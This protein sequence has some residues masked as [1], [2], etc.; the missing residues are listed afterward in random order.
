MIEAQVVLFAIQ[1]TLK[2]YAGAR[3]AYVDATLDREL[4]LPLPRA[5]DLSKNI[6]NI[7]Q[8]F[9]TG[10]GNEVRLENELLQTLLLDPT[11]NG[12]E[13]RT[14]YAYYFAEINDLD[15]DDMKGVEISAADL[16]HMLTIRQWG[17]N[18]DPGHPG[19]F[20]RMAGTIVE[21]A[22]DYFATMPG[23]V[24]E[25]RPE[26]RALLAFLK[27]MSDIE[28]ATENPR[29]LI[30]GVMI[31]V[32]DA[33]AATPALLVTGEKEQLLIVGMSTALAKA[34]DR[35]N[36]VNTEKKK[37]DAADWARVVAAAVARGAT[38]TVLAN[39]SLFLGKTDVGKFVL[40]DV[41]AQVADLAFGADK[42]ELQ[43]VLSTDGLTTIAQTA[44]GAISRN[45]EILGSDNTGLTKL[46]REVTGTLAASK[47]KAGRDLA[48]HVISLVLE[49]SAAN[50]DMLWEGDRNDPGRNLLVVAAKQT[51]TVL[52]GVVAGPATP[53]T[54]AQDQLVSIVDAVFAQV[55]ANPA[56]VVDQITGTHN[57]IVSAALT[58]ALA[59]MKGRKPSQFGAE[60][61]RDVL[62]A[63]I[64]AV[65]TRIEFLDHLPAGDAAAGK[66]FLT[67]VLDAILSAALEQPMPDSRRW[68][69]A[70][71]K[72]VQSLVETSFSLLGK[73]G[74]TQANLGILRTVLDD[75]VSG[76]ILP[77]DFAKTLES[78]LPA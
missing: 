64:V 52:S 51:L 46:V 17:K 68:Q 38:D 25:S 41:V 47:L 62:L 72:V 31:G 73:K 14:L 37:R 50:L 9:Q 20:Q 59:A 6:N 60:A 57:E 24:S 63:S 12:A 65:G 76:R 23:A 67:A 32:L 55:Q 40:Q 3:Q 44:L 56:W 29:Y 11:K 75:L 34:I 45:P 27:G 70:R 13:L 69:I 2:L 33:V 19:T 43:K 78:K 5:P 15:G 74:L 28:F 53:P 1:A 18:E 77:D 16:T 35:P 42:I 58:A 21:I 30:N 48:P 39:P 61:A 54:F 8:Y 22:V 36:D 4:I 49:C 10:E 7:V 66:A 26:G 71:T